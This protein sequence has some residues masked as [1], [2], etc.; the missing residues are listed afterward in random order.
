MVLKE[1]TIDKVSIVKIHSRRH[2]YHYIYNN[3]Y[4]KKRP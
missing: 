2:G 3:S 4:G 1:L